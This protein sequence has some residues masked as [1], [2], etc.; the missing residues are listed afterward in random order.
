MQPRQN[1]MVWMAWC[2]NTSE[3]TNWGVQ[4][5]AV[6]G[7]P[8]LPPPPLRR[9]P[10]PPCPPLGPQSTPPSPHQSPSQ[11]QVRRVGPEAQS[12]PHPWWGRGVDGKGWGH[13]QAASAGPAP[14]PAHSSPYCPCTGAGEPAR[15]GGVSQPGSGPTSPAVPSHVHLSRLYRLWASMPPPPPV[16]PAQKQGCA[17]QQDGHCGQGQHHQC[18]LHHLLQG[19]GLESVPPASPTPGPGHTTHRAQ[20]AHRLLYPQHPLLSRD[21]T[22]P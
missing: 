14:D 3:R 4:W 7:K 20:G 11:T 5:V 19:M 13:Q 17:K 8:G 16:L 6:R 15:E 10:H 2:M 18:G 21:I 22:A 9:A 1:S 12:S